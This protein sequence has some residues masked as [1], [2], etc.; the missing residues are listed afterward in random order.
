[1]LLADAGV[2]GT[3]KSSGQKLFLTLRVTPRLRADANSPLLPPVFHE[4]RPVLSRKMEATR[5]V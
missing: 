2:D 1:M 5:R 3:T 4:L